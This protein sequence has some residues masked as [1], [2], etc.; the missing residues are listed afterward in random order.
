MTKIKKTLNRAS[1]KPPAGDRSK[2]EQIINLLHRP[3]GPSLS[4]FMKV[5]GWQAHSVTGFL[6]GTLGKRQG[7]KINSSKVNDV[8]RY[9]LASDGAAP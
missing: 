7:L 4:E 8:R 2:A 3:T 6:S 9:H 5:T 1:A